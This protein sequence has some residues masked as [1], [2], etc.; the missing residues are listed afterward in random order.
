[1]C[2]THAYASRTRCCAIERVSSNDAQAI[3]VIEDALLH[4]RYDYVVAVTL[5][6]SKQCPLVPD[7]STLAPVLYARSHARTHAHTHARTLMPLRSLREWHFQQFV[8]LFFVGV[9]DN[10]LVCFS[11]VLR[12]SLYRF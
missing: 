3:V 2:A 8:S 4:P 9:L 11:T 1:M 10:L 6:L 12:A 7:A 5:F